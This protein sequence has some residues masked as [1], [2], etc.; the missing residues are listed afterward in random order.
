VETLETARLRLVPVS[1]GDFDALYAVYSEPEVSRFL[2]TQPRSREEFRAV[3]AQ[4]LELSASLGMWMIVDKADDHPIGRCGFY[5]YAGPPAAAPELAYLLSHA[6]WS[7]GLATEA[8][9]RCLDFAFRL[10]GWPE[11]VAMV[12]P[13]NLLSVRVL[14]KLGM[15]RLRRITVRGIPADLY[16]RERPVSDRVLRPRA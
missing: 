5:P 10:R 6:Y 2:I 7:R 8:A 16:R 15:R 4:M 3:F 9:A 13:E 1:T 11:V 12:R 14:S